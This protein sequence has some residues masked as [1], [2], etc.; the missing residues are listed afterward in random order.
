M[1]EYKEILQ[2]CEQ[3]LEEAK[4]LE[5]HEKIFKKVFGQLAIDDLFLSG[6]EVY[7]T[8][9]NETLKSS[10]FKKIEKKY[11]IASVSFVTN[12]IY[13]LPR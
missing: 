4:K 3:P 1:K 12:S 11:S 9:T 13:F 2:N 10:S 8:F 7:V 5:D 6:K